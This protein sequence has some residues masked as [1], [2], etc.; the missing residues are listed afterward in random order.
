MVVLSLQVGFDVLHV[1][2]GGVQE[3]ARPQQRE[4]DDMDTRDS[5]NEA[6]YRAR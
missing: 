5:N 2:L 6:G 4:A 3:S 1:G